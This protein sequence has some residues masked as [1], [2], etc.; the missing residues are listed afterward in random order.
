MTSVTKTVQIAVHRQINKGKAEA[1]I[2]TQDIF[3]KV[4]A[5]Y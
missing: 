3:N 2:H 1:I 5:F 4:I